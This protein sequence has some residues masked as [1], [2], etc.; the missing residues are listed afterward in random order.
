MSKTSIKTKI[1][2]PSHAELAAF[3]AFNMPVWVFDINQHSIWW[4]N[5]AGLDYWQTES[6][7]ALKTQVSSGSTQADRNLAV[8]LFNRLQD[9]RPSME[10][11]ILSPAGEPCEALCEC[12]LVSIENQRDAVFIRLVEQ[13]TSHA[14]ADNVRLQHSAYNTPVMVSMFDLDGK[15]L[16]ENPAAQYFRKTST[17]ASDYSLSDHLFDPQLAAAIIKSVQAG[18]PFSIERE[19]DRGS[20]KTLLRIT[21][22]GGHD[23]ITDK[24]VI[25]LTE[26][27]I[28]DARNMARRFAELNKHRENFL[29]DRSESFGTSEERYKALFE[30]APDAILMRDLETGEL[31]AANPA[32]AILFG[33]TI[34]DFLNGSWDPA[35]HMPEFQANG[36]STQQ[37]GAELVEQFF[38]K[39]LM[40]YEWNL[41]KADGSEFTAMVTMTFFPDRKRKIIR[42][43]FVDI[44]DQ[45]RVE[46]E[47]K[48]L[49]EQLIQSQKL[50]SVGQMTGGVAHDFNNL[51]S[52]ILG[53]MELLQDKLSNPDQLRHVDA[54]IKTIQRGAGL[55][56]NMLAFA[57]RSELYPTR[58]NLSTVIED[59]Q[60]WIAITIPANI[61]IKT[62]FAD[63]LWPVEVDLVSSESA[64]LNLMINAR[65][66]MPDGGV[67]SI[68]THNFTQREEGATELKPGRYAILRVGDTGS[69]IS[70]DNLQRVF[71]PFFS[72]KQS[73]ENSGLGL[74]MI[75]GFMNQSDGCAKIN[76]E[77]GKGTTVELFF[78][79]S[80][81]AL[82]TQTVDYKKNPV[83]D[84]QPARILIAE[85]QDMV[86]ALTKDMLTMEGYE[87]VTA[88]SGDEAAEKFASQG[89]FDLLLTDIV[90]PGKLQGSDLAR[91]LRET[92]ADLPVIFMSGYAGETSLRGNGL[93]ED[94]IRLMKPV[95]RK[96]LLSAIRMAMLTQ[97]YTD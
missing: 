51:L 76:S 81:N 23:P 80:A 73:G 84:Q 22:R 67:L 31:I 11:L 53:H 58:F 36:R 39:G 49:Q 59:L 66:A 95:A 25:F 72:T 8:R 40:T 35:N 78:P 18:E 47:R 38:K 87:V 69:G 20:G 85:D 24:T 79:A 48:A 19:I 30:Y 4:M 57:R 5:Q 15:L 91:K 42:T 52:V 16:V 26:D 88:S 10:K 45:K 17:I 12:R 34:E 82:E 14:D 96:D 43:S 3:E 2:I 41:L 55:A 92:V 62:H 94:D 1:V 13:I 68:E 70:A 97:Q 93:R 50:E 63:D 65:D 83:S 29:G 90:M 7:E 21:A 60:S 46:L 9:G 74:S 89:P 37:Y 32:A 44:S 86:L 56:R 64:L 33:V 77:I 54:T 28:T 27:N 75:H 61:Q 71:E 6:I